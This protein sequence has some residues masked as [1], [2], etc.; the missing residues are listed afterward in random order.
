GGAAPV[1]WRGA[2]SAVRYA[3][4]GLAGRGR[5]RPWLPAAG[6]GTARHHRGQGRDPLGLDEAPALAL[7]VELRRRRRAPPVRRARRARRQAACT[8]PR[9]M[10]GGGL[11]QDDRG[12][13]PRRDRALAP[14]VAAQRPVPGRR[15]PAAAAAPA[16]LA[17]T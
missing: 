13:P 15:R 1:L 3:D 6:A 10:A 14:S 8:G 7:A 16:A 12:G 2:R 11:R 9:G 17:G 5:R 4:R